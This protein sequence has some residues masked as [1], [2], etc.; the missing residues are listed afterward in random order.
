M[1]IL[2]SAIVR[3]IVSLLI[4]M[5]YLVLDCWYLRQTHGCKLRTDGLASGDLQKC[6]LYFSSSHFYIHVHKRNFSKFVRLMQKPLWFFIAENYVP[7]CWIIIW[8]LQF[9][10]GKLLA[11]IAVPFTCRNVLKMRAISQFISLSLSDNVTSL[12]GPPYRAV[13]S[14]CTTHY[15]YLNG[16]YQQYSLSAILLNNV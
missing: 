16:Q 4:V 11:G 10:L 7:E 14:V 2:Q 13:R 12:L 1:I 6:T 5:C 15:D 8:E 9:S 3:F